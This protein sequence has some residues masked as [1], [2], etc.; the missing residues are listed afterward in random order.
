MA[1]LVAYDDSDSEAETE[2]VGSFNPAGQ[3]K[4]ASDAVR[5]PGRDFAS[6]VL[7]AKDG[8][9]LP[10]KHGSCED[11]ASC[12]LPLARLWRSDSGSCPNQRLQWPRTEPEVT[13]PT[14]QP[15]RPSLWTSHAPAGHVPLAAARLKQVKLSWGTS[16]SPEPSFCARTGSE[17]PGKNGSSLQRQ[18][19][20]DC[21][22]P[23]TPK[24]LRQ[25]QALSTETGK[26]KD[27]EPQGPC[28][29]R[30]P[31][32]LC[33]APQVSEFIQPYLD[34]QYKETKIP[35][36]VLFHLR[37]HRGPVNNI[38]WCPV[39]SKSHMLLSTSM[40]KTFKVWNAVDSGSCL[41]TYSL[42]SE[43][44]RAA[45]WSPCGRHILSGGF[46]SALRLT[47][48]ETG[49]QLFSGQSDFRITTLKFHPRDHNV[50]VCG[51]FSSEMKA[52]D[53]RTSKV[54]RSYKATVQQ[55]LDI[56]FLREGSEFLSS[57]DASSRD[58]ADRT[59]I[60]WDFR[61]SAK[62]SNQIFH[63]R[64]TCPSLTLHPREPVF[65]AQT[66]GNYL[67]LFSAVWPYRMSRRRRY[68]G[69]K[70][71]G[72]SVGCECSP[73]GDL[74]LTGSADGRVLVY[75]FRTASRARTL[76]GHTQACVG[77]TF[78]PVLPSIL[79]TCSWEGDVK[80]WH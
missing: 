65:L 21:V 8:G 54:V 41:Q 73:D 52:W 20:E 34:S 76:H 77:T 79:A 27:M 32:P 60:A 44:V 49:T 80:I 55:T 29:G 46:D 69:H 74:L 13:F 14:S 24:R 11:A 47:D 35:R 40:D 68:E 67:A 15:A 4:D 75:S 64:Y 16:G 30:A 72:Y 12:H 23:Y 9:A 61:S 48:L 31:A 18:W 57:T 66:N 1:S 56:L 37:G 5:P 43:A 25:L 2:P 53:V 17:T 58:S 38:Q 22:V 71:E 6:E 3:M 42:H 33:V 45:R 59:I 70:V 39:S 50:F 10:T 51:G 78:H 7:D 62:I 26:S 36:K 28:A 19:C 63:E